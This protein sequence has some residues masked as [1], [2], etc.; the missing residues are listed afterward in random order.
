MAYLCIISK[1]ALIHRVDQFGC[2]KNGAEGKF[3]WFLHNEDTLSDDFIVVESSFQIIG[4]TE[5]AC[6]P[7]S[8]LVLERSGQ[9]K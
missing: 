7:R 4:V 6:L 2:H 5:K 8:S 1:Y 3:P 9:K